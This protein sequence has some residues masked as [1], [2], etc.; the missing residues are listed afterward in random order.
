MSS[1]HGGLGVTEEAGRCRVPAIELEGLRNGGTRVA[2]SVE[3]G[4]NQRVW[5]SLEPPNQVLGLRWIAV[6]LVSAFMLRAI[7][8][9]VFPDG[10]DWHLV[11]D[12]SIYLELRDNLI[13]T[14]SF[15][16]QDGEGGYAPEI[17]RVPGY[18]VYLTA[19]KQVGIEQPAAIAWSQA[20][21]DSATAVLIGLLGAM[22]APRVG[23]VA[24]LLAAAWP[25]MAITSTLVLND[26][27]FL[28]LFSGSLLCFA[29]FLRGPRLRLAV[30]GGLLFG[31]SLMVRPVYQFLP[32]ILALVAF[33][34]T[35][36]HGRGVLISTAFAVALLVAALAPPAHQMHRNLTQF[37]TISLTSQ[38][39]THLLGWVLPLV[40]WHSSEMPYDDAFQDALSGYR[41]HLAERGIDPTTLSSFAASQEKSRYVLKALGDIP[42]GDLAEAWIKGAIL[43]LA[44]PAVSADARLRAGRGGSLLEGEE[45]LGSGWAARFVRWANTDSAVANTVLILGLA[46]SAL[47][48]VLQ[49]VGVVAVWGRARWGVIFGALLAVY[50]LAIMGPVVGAK[51]RLPFAMVE[52]VLTAAGALAVWDRVRRRG[53]SVP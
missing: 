53:R 30:A 20:I 18:P 21:I 10:T 50:I 8:L 28:F 15:S 33:A 13:E 45:E 38:G 22:V 46:G 19:L 52:I 44:A 7:N 42:P 29:H 49:L 36:R 1:K 23:V 11:P 14:G 9:L 41:A 26:T 31:L 12:S 17:E 2:P 16:R 4:L 48:S 35:L 25:N 24:G 34:V 40:H 3:W 39:G 37:D 27:L 43:N 51:Y 47:V 32:P 5:N 6:I